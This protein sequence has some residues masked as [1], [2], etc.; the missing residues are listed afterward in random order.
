MDE[1]YVG[2]I[3]KNKH[4]NQRLKAAWG[5]IGKTVAA[6]VEDRETG[7]VSTEIGPSTHKAT[8]QGVVTEHTTPGA[9]AYTRLTGPATVVS[10][11]TLLLPTGE[12][13]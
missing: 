7:K 11:I 8:L 12:V 6:G 3:E 2:G 5:T 13:S 9:A 10:P 1:T 4:V